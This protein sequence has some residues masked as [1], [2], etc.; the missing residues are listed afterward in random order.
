VILSGQILP[1]EFMPRPVQ[2]VSYLAPNKHY[3]AI[4]RAVMLRGVGLSDLWPQ[5]IALGVL[6]VALYTVAAF[7]LRKRLD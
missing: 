1:V 3:T 2:M 4:V 6:G 7:R 5:V